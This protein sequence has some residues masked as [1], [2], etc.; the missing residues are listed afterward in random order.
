[1]NVYL[2]PVA[3]SRYQLYV[4]I[5]A[6][7]AAAPG[8]STSTP[9]WMVRQVQRFRATLAEAEQER[10]RRERGEPSS[11][12]GLW[13]TAMGKIAESVAEQRLLWHLRHQTTVELN[14][15]DD[16]DGQAAVRELRAEFSRDVAKHLRWMIIDGAA[17]AITGPVFFFL[18][19]PNIISWYFTFRV[20]GHFFSWRGARKGL[21]NVEWHA[22]PSALLTA[23][24]P[25]LS[26]GPPDRRH[27][28]EGIAQALGL[29]HLAGFVERV[30]PRRS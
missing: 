16:L 17:V 2:V 6:D 14:H 24:R 26:L 22:V 10:L 19:G 15:P 23:V 20:V 29:Q 9:G 30:A 1:M 12:S 27:R 8:V 7:A 18:P 13:R 21:S 28:L 4:E 3:A 11:G 25:A 5:A